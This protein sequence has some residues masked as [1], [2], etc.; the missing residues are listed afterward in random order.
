M[1]MYALFLLIVIPLVYLLPSLLWAWRD[2]PGAGFMFFLNLLLGWT[3]LP[4]L[5]M[6][7]VAVWPRDRTA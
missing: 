1:S 3:L 6:M 2:I 4:W 5:Y 7:A